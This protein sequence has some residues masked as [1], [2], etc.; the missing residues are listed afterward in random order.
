MVHECINS[1]VK[2][3]IPNWKDMEIYFE[4]FNMCKWVNLYL[5]SE[6]VQ[7]SVYAAA[8]PKKMTK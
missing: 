7:K 8:R 3:A 6:C 5:F 4:N 2:D 1:K